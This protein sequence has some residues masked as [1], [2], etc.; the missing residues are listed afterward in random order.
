[1][2]VQD[3]IPAAWSSGE[4]FLWH[5]VVEAQYV[6][7]EMWCDTVCGRRVAFPQQFADDLL[8]LVDRDIDFCQCAFIR[9][10]DD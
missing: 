3:T 10:S 4:P 8:V 7:P 5:K 6:P 1:V 2:L 9:S